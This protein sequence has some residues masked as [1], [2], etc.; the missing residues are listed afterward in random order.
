V[1]QLTSNFSLPVSISAINKSLIT[2]FFHLGYQNLV[3]WVIESSHMGYLL[4]Y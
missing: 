3:H 2:F 1:D 4:V